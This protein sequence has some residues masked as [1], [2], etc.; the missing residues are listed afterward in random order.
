[1]LNALPDKPYP[2]VPKG[3]RDLDEDKQAVFELAVVKS[4][5]FTE[6][7]KEIAGSDDPLLDIE[8]VKD[9]N[10]LDK[11]FRAEV[12]G[13]LRSKRAEKVALMVLGKEGL[14]WLKRCLK[15]W[16][17]FMSDGEK[18]PFIPL[19]DNK[20]P[21]E[22]IDRIPAPLRSELV[23]AVASMNKLEEPERKK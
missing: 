11:E 16:K 9:L 7:M 8:L 12:I 2:Y 14:G 19:I 18:V 6:F 21:I 5:E 15:G 17:N 20:C 22:N 4:L 1:M 13:Q 3:Q 10:G 23:N